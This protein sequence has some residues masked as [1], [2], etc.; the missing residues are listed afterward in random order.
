MSSMPHWRSYPVFIDNLI[1][2]DD[3]DTTK[4]R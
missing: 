3:K 2:V 1:T 4:L